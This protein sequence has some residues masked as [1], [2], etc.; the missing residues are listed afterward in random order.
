MNDESR[1]NDQW[2]RGVPLSAR[3]HTIA[4]TVI[5]LAS[6]GGFG[7]WAGLAPLNGAVVASGTFVATG[8]NKL[9][10]HLEGGIIRKLLVSEGDLVEPDQVLV[11]IDETPAMSK[12]RRLIVRKFRLISMQTR[13]QAEL[14][15]A[16]E[17]EMPQVLAANASD[18]ELKDIFDR[19][20]F[21]LQARRKTLR[22]QEMVLRN[23]IAGTRESIQG[24]EAQVKSAKDRL[25]LFTEELQDKNTLLDRQ[26]VRKSEVLALQ[27]SEASLVGDL[28]EL[29]GRIADAKERI[30]RADHQIVQIHST[31]MQKAVEE[32][33]QTET[34]LDDI[35]EQIRAVQ[36]IVERTDV[37]APVRGIV[38]KLNFHTFGGVVAPGAV[39]MELLP[40]SDELVVKANLN[41]TDIS[42][43]HAGQQALVRLSALNRRITPMVEAKVIYVSA[44]ALGEQSPL[45]R[46]DTSSRKRDQ[47]S[48]KDFYLVRVRLDADDVRKRVEGF[49]AT[50]GMPADVYI[51]TGERTFFEYIMRPVYDSFSR[52]F[53][54]S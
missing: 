47:D 50:P 29:T 28:G 23:E 7:A 36:D 54:E 24:Y 35:Q 22:A 3:R 38:V 8:Q 4:G 1:N 19:Q 11:H 12:L 13:L 46:S 20:R 40:V 51:R 30:A 45:A 33:R 25:S 44:D 27:R 18:P 26:L 32:L 42:H 39:I 31:A 15:G 10:Q 16:E 9:V 37:R 43:V 17:I 34:E 14:N 48:L 52:A 41:P 49:Q 2:Y 53:R 21:E 5:L 6:V